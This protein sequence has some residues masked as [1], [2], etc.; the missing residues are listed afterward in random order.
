MT[1]TLMA[2]HKENKMDGIN[3]R[4][5]FDMK[6]VDMYCELCHCIIVNWASSPAGFCSLSCAEKHFQQ[7]DR[8]FMEERKNT[9]LKGTFHA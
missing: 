4:I 3:R 9:L 2:T 5:S 7:H 8:K 1:A 6:G